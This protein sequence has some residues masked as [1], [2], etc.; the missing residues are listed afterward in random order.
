MRLRFLFPAAALPA[1][2][3]A[4]LPTQAQQFLVT[5]IADTNTLIPGSTRTFD[6]IYDARISDGL[7]T[8]MGR[9]P[10]VNGTREEWGIYASYGGT[11]RPLV[12]KNTLMPDAASFF[13][14]FYGY[15]LDGDRLAFIGHG[16]SDIISPDPAGIYLLEGGTINTVVNRTTPI[17]PDNNENFTHF[18]GTPSIQGNN[19]AFQALNNG[20]AVFLY[21]NGGSVATKVRKLSFNLL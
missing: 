19:V 5:K 12:D 4:P 13:T 18:R 9:G 1:L 17:P 16:A 3:T 6:N 14:Q 8:F 7:I 21:S 11:V 20:E 2:L 15:S 10:R